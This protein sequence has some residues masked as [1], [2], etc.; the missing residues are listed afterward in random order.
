[1]LID[2]ASTRPFLLSKPN[3][4][5]V[6]AW[7]LY[8]FLFRETANKTDKTKLKQLKPEKF[9]GCF[10]TQTV[11]T[12]RSPFCS[13]SCRPSQSRCKFRPGTGD[14]PHTWG[15]RRA[16]PDQAPLSRYTGRGSA[17]HTPHRDSAAASLK[18]R[19]PPFS[20]LGLPPSFAER[21]CYTL[22]NLLTQEVFF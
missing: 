20:V 8:S 5:F 14:T 15:K 11:L 1:M 7:R 22:F 3:P 4:D 6:R 13:R 21:I 10:R 9:W 16:T 19:V 17:L 18:Y 2:A 12:W